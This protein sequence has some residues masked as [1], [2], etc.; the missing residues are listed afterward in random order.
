MDRPGG[1]AGLEISEDHA[2]SPLYA[3]IGVRSCD[4]HAI[5]VQDRVFLEGGYVD[6]DYRRRRE[7][8]FV[9]AVNCGQAAATT[10]VAP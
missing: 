1:A 9:V 3:F 5:A 10:S 7:G 4:L 6:R 8:A 2:P